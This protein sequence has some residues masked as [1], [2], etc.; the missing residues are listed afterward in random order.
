MDMEYSWGGTTRE[1]TWD[2]QKG[3]KMPHTSVVLGSG[4]TE[5]GRAWGPRAAHGGG[6]APSPA[7]SLA[8]AAP[9]LHTLLSCFPWGSLHRAPAQ[10][11]APLCSLSSAGQEP[12]DGPE[13]LELARNL[14]VPVTVA[15]GSISPG[16][17]TSSTRSPQKAPSWGSPA[18]SRGPLSHKMTHSLRGGAPAHDVDCR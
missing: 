10:A 2:Q 16:N 11:G 12:G 5:A 3:T 4:S 7:L 1:A 13:A 6:C 8:A 9:A 17:R 18:T 15:S 14:S